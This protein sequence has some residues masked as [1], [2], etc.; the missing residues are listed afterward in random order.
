MPPDRRHRHNH[1]HL[2]RQL[3][4]FSAHSNET[5]GDA[6][7]YQTGFGLTV[8]LLVADWPRRNLI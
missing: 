2:P 3:Q 6:D 4:I 8:K 1:F 7:A 5:F